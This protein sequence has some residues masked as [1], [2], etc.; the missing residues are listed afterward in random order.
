MKKLNII[1]AVKMPIGTE[2]EVH[3]NDDEQ[4]I[5][6]MILKTGDKGTKYLDWIDTNIPLRVFAFLADT[7]FIPIQKPVSFIE[8]ITSGKR[9]KCEY[10]K[11]NQS[12]IYMTMNTLFKLFSL[13][14]SA[15][16]I[17]NLIKEG[18]W[19]IEED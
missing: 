13:S 1:E 12:G 15:D 11:F 18:K 7:T 17:P 9:I 8:A 19:F 16:F 4:A 14:Y 10:E 5:A 3:Y 2:F 6:N